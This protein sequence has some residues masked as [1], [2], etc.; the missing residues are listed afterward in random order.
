MKEVKTYCFQCYNGPDPFKMIVEDGIV[1]HIEPDFDCAGI[2]PGEG[3][4]CVKAY[5]LV[6]KMYNPNRIKTPLIRTNPKKGKN[7][8]PR[9]REATWDEALELVAEKLREI[10]KKGLLD[11]KGYPRLA[12]SMGEAGSPAGYGGTFPAFLSA[13]GPIDFTL[14]GG[15]G[16]KCY[17][18][19]HLY[20]ELW[21]RAFIV[22]SDTPRNRW[23]LSFGHNTNASAGVSGAMR[24]AD[25]RERGYKRIQAEP[26]LSVS[27]VTS[28]EWIPIKTKTDAPFMY[29]MINVILHEMAWEKVCDIDF[30]KKRTNSPYLIG[31]R[32]YYLRDIETGEVLVWDS[33]EGASKIYN[34]PS[35]KDFAL[36]GKYRVRAKERGPDGE[37]WIYDEA[38]CRPAFQLLLEHMRAYTPEWAS[39]VCDVP[40]STIRRIARE[41]IENASIGAE[42]EICGEK[43][44]LR[45]V[46]ITLGKTI[47]NGPGGYQACWARTI[48]AM[49]TGSLEVAGG[50]VGASQRLNRP[51]HD[52]WSSIW[53]GEDG[54]F[55]NFLNPTD[56]E[57]RANL[58]K[59]RS[60]YTELVPLVGNTGWSPFLSPVPHAWLW[61]S[62]SP[63]NWEKPTYPDVW[64]IYRT[65]P[66]M[67]MY[68][69]DLME[70]T[71][72]E[73]PFIVSIGYTLDETNWYADVILP[74]HTD[75][76]GLQLFRVGPSTHSE[77]YWQEYG[78]ALRQPGTA[79]PYNTM[80]MTELSTELAIRTGILKEYNE[81]INA[82]IILGIRLQGRGYNYMLNPD[83]R[84]SIEE[85][86]DRLCRASVR[87]LT[88]GKEERDL[89]WFKQNGYFTVV[90][91]FIRHFLHPVMVK[92]G[93]RYEIP[94]QG[95]L[96]IIG[97]ELK[98]RLEDKGIKWWEE[99]LKEYEALPR[100]E[101]FSQKWDESVRALGLDPDEYPFYMVNTRS[102]QYAWGSNASLPIMAEMAKYVTGFGGIVINASVAE[103]LG[104]EDGDT[105]VVESP[106]KKKTCRAIVREGIR[107]DTVLVT[108]QFGN[109]AVPFAKD[110]KIPSLNEFMYPDQRLF[111]AG[112]S[113]ADIVKV[114]VYKITID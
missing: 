51:H 23:T 43:I 58:P 84:Y 107:P 113:S 81:A 111:D 61:F 26:H 63:E 65:N 89:E 88:N 76:E 11:E 40:A 6:Q 50:S 80:D 71:T 66:N 8:D 24:H 93:L 82:G 15:E 53:P 94:Y 5:G 48:L 85:I 36:T 34:D 45:P 101:D 38:E 25:A 13:W 52:R 19:E 104:I 62:Q 28:D 10:R 91:P 106:V 75:L 92:W 114:K 69:T 9:F 30:I 73:F 103:K 39:E 46:A 110:L 49:L 57:R 60:H 99:Q 42:I 1:R 70:E 14:G 47:S 64:I 27:A 31:P 74:E 78:F 20:G 29:A 105:V 41:M 54:F 77:A 44:P 17:H 35:I 72:K 90:Y 4:V 67:S 87:L 33:V 68:Y 3:R 12:V 7:E 98:R 56:P 97:E 79:P 95:R 102:M 37:E 86:W 22:A 109:W 96:K 16:S 83:R 112:G 108:G 32:G 21:H 100:C 59:T 55:Q 2:S 18:A